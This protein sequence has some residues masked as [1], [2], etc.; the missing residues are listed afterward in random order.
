MKSLTDARGLPISTRDPA[1]VARFERALAS[2]QLADGHAAA[3]IDEMLAHEPQFAMAHCLR[4]AARLLGAD[5]MRQPAAAASIRSIEECPHGANHRE[6]RHAAAARAGLEGNA[7]LALERYGELVIDYPHDSLA[8]HMAHA[9]DFRLGHREMLR[10]RVAEVLPHWEESIPGFGHVL[11]M[12][13]FGLEETGDYGRAESFARRSLSLEPR[14]AAAMHVIAHVM[15]MQGRA[16]E[17][18]RWLKTTRP[19]WAANAGFAIHN[20]WHLALFHID[21]GAD[22]EALAIYDQVLRPHR[23]SPVAALADASALLWRLALRDIDLRARWRAL[24][25]YWK[26]KPLPGQR[27]FYLVHALMA[28]AAAGETALARRVSALLANDPD[29]RSASADDDLLLALPLADGLQAFTRRDYARA[30]DAINRVRAIAHRCGGSVAQCD[31]IHLT[32]TEAALRS[33]RSH[34]ARAL[35]AERA[36]RKPQSPLNRLLFAR[37]G[38]AVLAV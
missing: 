7:K 25:R 36:A 29:T 6:R 8:L 27:A 23:T 12:Y 38:A 16:R 19:V 5:V 14:H 2:W 37:A 10:D 9:L 15:E 33:R 13:A 3:R 20:A 11:G 26:R 32:L 28:F 24:A 4:A 17:G 31:L 18:I 35:A 22:H 34:L 21:V 30:V 1:S